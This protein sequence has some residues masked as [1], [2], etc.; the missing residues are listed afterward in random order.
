MSAVPAG[1]PSGAALEVV[2]LSTAYGRRTVLDSVRLDVA[3]GGWLAVIGPNGSGKSTL[4]RCV[5]GF[6]PYSGLIRLDGT[7]T[8]GMPRRLRARRLPGLRIVETLDR[9]GWARL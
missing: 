2:G 6:Q 7:D 1:S 8:A 9:R 5:L 4:L 3:P